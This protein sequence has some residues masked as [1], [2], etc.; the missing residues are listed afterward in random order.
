MGIHTPYRIKS[1]GGLGDVEAENQT[2]KAPYQDGSTYIGSVLEE[3]IIP[4]EL[5]IVGTS[6]DDMSSKRQVLSRIFNPKCGEGELTL[7]IG[8]RSLIANVVS[9]FIPKFSGTTE[10]FGEN[11]QRCLLQVTAHQPYWTEKLKV[12]KALKA[13]QGNF[14]VPFSFPMEFGISGEKTILSNTG[15]VDTPVTI[16]IQGPVVNPQVRNLT[17]GQVFRINKSVSSNEVIH[18]DTTP[19]AKRVEVIR[20]G[21]TIMSVMGWVDYAVS[22]FWQLVPGDNEIE[23]TADAGD[24]GA[25]VAVSWHNRYAGM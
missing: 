16:E 25:I 13:Y 6:F 17:T 23:Y 5:K 15:H 18:I 1:I 22:D 7:G 3:R 11:F 20:D 4:I 19:M 2:Q 9:D 12:S 10:G 21:L 24:Q 14:S 8:S